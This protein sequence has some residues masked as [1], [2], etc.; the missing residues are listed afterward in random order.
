M[1]NPG[2]NDLSL[3]LERLERDIRWWRLGALGALVLLVGLGAGARG[4]TLEAE[5]V[6]IRDAEGR[7]RVMI[8]QAVPRVPGQ[9]AAIAAFAQPEFGLFIYGEGDRQLVNLTAEGRERDGSASLNMM[10]PDEKVAAELSLRRRLLGTGSAVLG[11]SSQVDPA[12]GPHWMRLS[13]MIMLSG[14]SPNSSWAARMASQRS[15]ASS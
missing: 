6:V 11:L 2:L 13:G 1:D 4:A 9:P 14:R 7:A 5:R 15:L 12:L 8:G 3:R 10:S